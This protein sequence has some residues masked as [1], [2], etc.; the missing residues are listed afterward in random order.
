VIQFVRMK[1]TN[2]IL[3]EKLLEQA[4]ELTGERTY[5]AVINRALDEMVRKLV[6]KRGLESMAN[7][8]N[9]WP[10]YAESLYGEEWV[11]ETREALRKKGLL[12]E[13]RIADAPKVV[14][15][16]RRASR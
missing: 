6:I 12:R 14:S 7:P 4:R 5:S 1:R 9:W 13:D 16:K 2:V 11:R 3:D 15:R 8:D 10:G